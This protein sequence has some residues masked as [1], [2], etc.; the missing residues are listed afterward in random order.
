MC[1]VMEAVIGAGSKHNTIFEI[2]DPKEPISIIF[3]QI[4]YFGN[5]KGKIWILR[6]K[7]RLNQ[8]SDRYS[9]SAV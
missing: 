8:K 2:N 4:F 7:P 9:D 6:L 1:R 5:F 3:D